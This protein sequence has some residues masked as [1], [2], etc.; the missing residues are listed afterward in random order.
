MLHRFATLCTLFSLGCPSGNLFSDPSLASSSASSIVHFARAL[1]DYLSPHNTPTL[2][3][4]IVTA[5][6]LASRGSDAYVD[7]NDRLRLAFYPRASGALGASLRTLRCEAASG[8]ACG[9]FYAGSEAH[10]AETGGRRDARAIADVDDVGDIGFVEDTSLST[11]IKTELWVRRFEFCELVD[12]FAARGSVRVFVKGAASGSSHTASPLLLDPST[13]DALSIAQCVLR[14]LRASAATAL[15]GTDATSR[16]AHFFLQTVVGNATDGDDVLVLQEPAMCDV[17]R[18]F[19]SATARWVAIAEASDAVSVTAASASASGGRL[20]N[21]MPTNGVYMF[22]STRSATLPKSLSGVLLARDRAASTRGTASS[23]QETLWGALLSDLVALRTVSASDVAESGADAAGTTCRDDAGATALLRA[24]AVGCARNDVTRPP[25]VI[26]DA[27]AHHAGRLLLVGLLGSGADALAEC[28]ARLAADSDGPP[29]LVLCLLTSAAPARA[30]APASVWSAPRSELIAW[31]AEMSN[32]AATLVLTNARAGD[33]LRR[34]LHYALAVGDIAGWHPTGITPP[35]SRE[36]LFAPQHMFYFASSYFFVH[37]EREFKAQLHTRL[38]G[39]VS[40]LREFPNTA[41]ILSDASREADELAN[42]AAR[43]PEPRVCTHSPQTPRILVLSSYWDRGH[44]SHRISAPLSFALARYTCATLW[45]AVSDAAWNDARIARASA[46]SEARVNGL[47]DTAVRDA[48]EAAALAAV[49]GPSRF[50]DVSAFLAFARYPTRESIS[51]QLG[52]WAALRDGG[53]R[54][55]LAERVPLRVGD[56]VTADVSRAVHGVAAEIAAEGQRRA[57]PRE[58]HEYPFDGVLYPSVGMAPNDM[59]LAS[60]RVAHVQMVTYGHSSSTRSPAMDVFLGGTEPEVFGPIVADVY[61]VGVDCAVGLESLASL[62]MRS[63]TDLSSGQLPP[64]GSLVGGTSADSTIRLPFLAQCE[65]GAQ[66]CLLADRYA[67]GPARE[68]A[69]GTVAVLPQHCVS[70][71]PTNVPVAETLFTRLVD[72]QR[73]YSERLVLLPG[74]GMWFTATFPI[75]APAARS[76]LPDVS[77]PGG[78][79][80]L[81]V[82]AALFGELLGAAPGAASASAVVAEETAKWATATGAVIDRNAL[83]RA[84]ATVAAAVPWPGA[85]S[86]DPLEIALVWSVVKWNSKQLDR[87]L[88]A[89]HEA[90]ARWSRAWAQC[91]KRVASAASRG[92][93]ATDTITSAATDLLCATLVRSFPHAPGTL[94]ARLVAFSTS[95]GDALKGVAFRVWLRRLLASDFP[96]GS[97]RATFVTNATTPASYYGRLGRTS[98]AFDSLPFAACNTLQD[99]LALRVPLVSA[100]HDDEFEAGIEA[101][102]GSPLRWRS[103]IGASMLT[104]VGLSGLAAVGTEDL[105]GKAAHLIAN[106]LL[107]SA[108]RLR[109]AEVDEG[110]LSKGQYADRDAQIVS[111]VVA[112]MAGG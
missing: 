87:L 34:L 98:L 103:T 30:C 100:A 44:S 57:A 50:D 104:R 6:G 32:T 19:S 108:W 71:I 68:S 21:T 51:L 78:R 64:P 93:P 13:D 94:H 80:A 69:S 33:T 59:L 99:V 2:I 112:K 61:R 28:A 26:A 65:A 22:S 3:H 84:V 40:R 46:I 86:D 29:P 12:L 27:L 60:L 1:S 42:E 52:L 11:E 101:A 18:G 16:L 77:M 38:A 92:A 35:N 23:G 82:G 95:D 75:F 63:I 62:L 25:Q 53:A 66:G 106:P 48:G 56:A 67:V 24:L 36:L 39:A 49:G 10:G 79:E 17:V 81:A 4:D 107:R 55:F 85:T 72:A 31:W 89:L 45:H 105:G 73:R 37:L 47:N 54:S 97:V 90:Q 7:V 70:T 43:G 88:V 14:R 111:A 109:M 5:V 91:A 76:P 8:D 83:A 58:R 15:D 74:I 102:K 96:D 20:L 9:L 41:Y 110:E